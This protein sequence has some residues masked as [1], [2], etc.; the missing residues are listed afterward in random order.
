MFTN[1]EIQENTSRRFN[2]VRLTIEG[3]NVVIKSLAGDDRGQQVVIPIN[4]LESQVFDLY[5][6]GQRWSFEFSGVTWTVFEIGL[7]LF[8]YIKKNLPEKVAS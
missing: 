3:A 7:G 5:W 2:H 8:E 6:G 1:L 4:K